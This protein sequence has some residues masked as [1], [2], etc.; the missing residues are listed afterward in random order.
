MFKYSDGKIVLYGIKNLAS[1]IDNVT[2]MLN[3]K[4]KIFEVKL[5]MIEAITNA[6]YHGNMGNSKKP[7]I[8]TWSLDKDSINISVKDCGSRK[9]GYEDIKK[10]DDNILSESG[11]GL[12]IIKSYSDEVKIGKGVISIKKILL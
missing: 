3:I 2:A 12:E 4:E 11:R 1:K 10:S 9:F 6:F 8:I 7:I 5:I